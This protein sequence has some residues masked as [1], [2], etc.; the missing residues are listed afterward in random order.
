MIHLKVSY[1]GKSKK[2]LSVLAV[3]ITPHLSAIYVAVLNNGC[4]GKLFT[5]DKFLKNAFI[6]CPI[7]YLITS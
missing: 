7:N 6:S 1:S 2:N 3:T 5:D 4:H